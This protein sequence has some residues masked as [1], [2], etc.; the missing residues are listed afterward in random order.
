M[1]F[2]DLFSCV[3]L[4]EEYEEYVMCYV[5]GL[6]IDALYPRSSFR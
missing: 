5:I 2:M 6:N 3:M 4:E 1:M